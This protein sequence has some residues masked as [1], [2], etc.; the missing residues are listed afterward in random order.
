MQSNMQSNVQG[1]RRIKGFNLTELLIVVAIVGILGG[2]AYPAYQDSVKRSHRDA[3]KSGLVLLATEMTRA[4][5]VSATNNYANLAD[6]SN[7]PIST[8]FPSQLPLDNE[9][10]TY[11]ITISTNESAS[12]FTLTATP[13][14]GA[15][16]E[17]DGT[18][19]LAS[20]G[21]KTWNGA[22]GWD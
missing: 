2:V 14:E 20:T 9:P 22:S 15:L 21:A 10:K 6:E 13:I 3:A 1:H 19:T 17:G 18:L 12:E 8:L 5:T 16:M 11:D 7:A 4:K